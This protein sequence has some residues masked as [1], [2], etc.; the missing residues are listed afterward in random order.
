MEKQDI[1]V[2]A[3]A[4]VAFAVIAL[5]VRPIL[6]GPYSVQPAGG[7]F[8]E[9]G[10]GTQLTYPVPGTPSAQV[11]APPGKGTL[12]TPPPTTTQPWNGKAKDVGFI[13]QPADQV[14]PTPNPPIPQLPVQ[15]QSLVTY[16]TISNQ[17]SGTTENLYVP[18]PWWVLEYTADPTALPPDAFP[19]LV[20]QV[21]DTQDPNRVVTSPIVQDIFVEP[22][23]DTPWSQK[24]YEGKRTYYFKVDAKFLKSYTITVKVPQEYL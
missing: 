3:A 8:P 21:F 7:A 16:A 1:M 24:I 4:I 6:A 2:V 17:W 22:D 20:I 11:T 15:N 12:A 10:T 23:S 19:K 5:F 9:G 13:S 18:T 14:T